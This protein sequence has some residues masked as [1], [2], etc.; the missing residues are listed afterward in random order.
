MKRR[1]AVASLA[2][3][4]VVGKAS[5]QE[6]AVDTVLLNGR[7]TRFDG[8][9]P[10]QALAIRGS[11]IAAIGSDADMS[12]LAG[13]RTRVIDLG[14]RCVIPGLIDTHLHAIR[15]GLTWQSE[16]SWIDVPSLAEALDRLRARAAVTPKGGWIVV[17]GGWTALQFAEAR[18][19]SLAEIAAV[20]PEHRVFV[21]SF[22]S[23]ILLSPG[24]LEQLSQ[25]GGAAVVA[26]LGVERDPAGMPTGWVTGTARAI[27]ELYDLLP[28]PDAAQQIAGTRALF[29]AL[30]GMGLT[31][32][33]DQ[34]GYNLGLDDYQPLLALWRKRK[35]SL[36]VR[37]TLCAPRP[38]SEQADFSELT[39]L[40]PMG[41]GD[42]WLRF[43][44][45]GANVTWGMYDNQA[46]DAA[47]KAHQVVVLR[48][49]AAQGL[50]VTFQ[51]YDDSSVHHLLEVVEAVD[52]DIPVSALRWSIAHLNDISAATI[53]RM[54][55][56]G[57]G[58]L[59]QDALYFRGEAF[60]ATRGADAVMRGVPPIVSALRSGIRIGAGTDATRV[61]TPNPF[62]ALQWM[63]DGR[64]VGGLAMRS[65]EEIPGRT[66]A[67]RLY[68][69]SGAWFGFDEADTGT[70]AVGRLADLAVLSEDYFSVSVERVGA[71]TSLLTMVGG[72]IVYAERN[73]AQ[74]EE[75]D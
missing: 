35:L 15:A 12:G 71:I 20:A 44:G 24:A 31:G 18:G 9:Q 2:Y 53:A 7:I 38:G 30:N 60:V 17:D 47:Q 74:L 28:K 43:V 73:F 72:R 42:E 48:W 66:D 62:V 41:F 14:G 10:A 11:R 4:A 16:V 19:P 54:K 37:Y 58:W 29:R 26:R 63:L 45:L 23:R 52:V 57:M 5:A 13:Q 8:E 75:A 3:L 65:P 36:R 34:G 68:T 46:P 70:L 49:A 69:E 61:M 59:M 55:A 22:Y 64:T 39:R 40:L 56:L 33:I 32:F 50:S 1:E 27:S 51:W 21:Q 25:G 67:L 6:R